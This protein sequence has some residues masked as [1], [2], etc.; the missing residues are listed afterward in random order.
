[1]P[2]ELSSFLMG[3]TYSGVVLPPKVRG[4]ETHGAW[5]VT[6]AGDETSVREGRAGPRGGAE[7]PNAPLVPS[8]A[9]K[10]DLNPGIWHCS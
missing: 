6:L 1:M 4:S 7:H 10:K 5:S 8:K 3:P 9:W 2:K